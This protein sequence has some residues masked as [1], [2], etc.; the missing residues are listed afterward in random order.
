MRGNTYLT[1]PGGPRN[2]GWIAQTP[3]IELDMTGKKKKKVN[4]IIASDLLLYL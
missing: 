4:K 2:R 1:L 3:R